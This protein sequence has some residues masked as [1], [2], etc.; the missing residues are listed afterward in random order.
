MPSLK[1]L[2]DD[3][4]TEESQQ[5][6]VDFL[7]ETDS[8][9]VCGGSCRQKEI[10]SS[11]SVSRI[12][13]HSAHLFLIGEDVYK[14]KRAVKYSYLDMTALST[15]KILCCRELELNKQTLPKIYLAVIPITLEA[16]EILAFDGSGKVVEWVLHMKRFAENAIL[17]NI[18]K[19]NKLTVQ[20]ASQIGR[21]VAFY[22]ETLESVDVCD[23]YARIHE[24]VT[25]LIE[26][27][28][29][30]KTLF[31]EQL[32]AR[33]QERGLRELANCKTLL[34]ARAA[35]GY[36]KRCHG[37]LHLRNIVL[38][39]GIPVPFDA[40]EFDE[41]MATTDV[42]Y[43]LAFILMDLDHR[44]LFE[45]SNKT[46]NQYLLYSDDHSISGLRL[47]SLFMFCRAGIRAMTIAQAARLSVEESVSFENEA[48]SYCELALHY[49]E[50]KRPVLVAIGGLS[51]TG[52]STVAASF[53]HMLGCPPG[54]LLLRSDAERKVAL[55][56]DELS[57]LSPEHY[58]A[59][60]LDENYKRLLKK[61]AMAIDAGQSVIVDAVFLDEA[62]REAV[63][64]LAVLQHY[65][66]I[67]IWL[68]APTNILEQRILDRENDASDATISVLNKQLLADR[69]KMKWHVVDTSG[70]VEHVLAEISSIV[71][72]CVQENVSDVVN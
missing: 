51:G 69:G 52:K 66:F 39:D 25:E 30:Y 53:S 3:I 11:E 13:T 12:S 26:E 59:I 4:S 40:L 23:G 37:D 7:C 14:I 63:E 44:S 61:T 16:D 17:D 31:S 33:F 2:K 38:I 28:A 62:H 21:S 18:A 19:N 57:T 6:V 45:Q 64:G 43:D 22:H 5:A 50:K 67:G 60:A 48:K 68:E 27:L 34:D 32:L 8:Y 70:T 72:N 9:E 10:S 46:L 36:V 47:L 24:V 20:L 41:R 49:L 35:Q 1:E 71:H 58:T 42:L 15:R 29:Q 54:S 65:T 55:G 56:V